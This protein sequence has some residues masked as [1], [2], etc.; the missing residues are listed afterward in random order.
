MSSCEMDEM[1][2][3]V[4]VAYL[5]KTIGVRLGTI[6]KLVKEHDGKEFFKQ[7]ST[8]KDSIME[9]LKKCEAKGLKLW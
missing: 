9:F 4:Y 8:S 7:Y 3:L 1:I 5:G 2:R 6:C